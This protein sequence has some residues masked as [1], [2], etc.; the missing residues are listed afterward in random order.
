MGV[1]RSRVAAARTTA[2]GLRR[3]LRRHPA[4]ATAAGLL[5]VGLLVSASAVIWVQGSA[6]RGVYAVDDVPS[7]PVAIVLG[8]GVHDGT[9]SPYL[10]A[11][12]DDAATLYRTG[13][14]QA[15]LVSGDHGR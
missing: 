3:A 1:L 11:R 9:P 2:N 8:A 12:L 15:I 13:K 14:V 5:T 7:A 10:Q 4:R 6:R